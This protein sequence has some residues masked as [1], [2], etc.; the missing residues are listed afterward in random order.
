MSIL[1]T[2]YFENIDSNYKKLKL[3]RYLIIWIHQFF[4]NIKFNSRKRKPYENFYIISKLKLVFFN[5]NIIRGIVD[6][7]SL[8]E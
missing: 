7:S 2:K 6:F 4:L 8:A 3:F 1:L 5:Y